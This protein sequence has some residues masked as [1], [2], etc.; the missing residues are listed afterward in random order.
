MFSNLF[1]ISIQIAFHIVFKFCITAGLIH[2][3]VVEQLDLLTTVQN[4]SHPVLSSHDT[5][6]NNDLLSFTYV[7]NCNT[8]PIVESN[9]NNN[10]SMIKSI[11]DSR[12][13]H[14]HHQQQQQPII[15]TIKSNNIKLS[16]TDLHHQSSSVMSN[17]NV[18]YILFCQKYIYNC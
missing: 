16:Q 12:H 8:A 9:N 3:T 10:E 13:R 4:S 2:R 7:T 15:H 11:D 1:I 6:H 17:K 18:C 5:G 14:H